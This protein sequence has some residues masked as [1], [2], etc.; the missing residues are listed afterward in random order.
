MT[1]GKANARTSKCT[2]PA[3]GVFFLLVL[4]ILCNQHTVPLVS[5]FRF[6]KAFYGGKVDCA[7]GSRHQGNIVE[8]DNNYAAMCSQ[9]QLCVL[10]QRI[11]ALHCVRRVFRDSARKLLG[12]NTH[13]ATRTRQ[14]QRATIVNQ[15]IKR[16]SG[17]ASRF[18]LTSGHFARPL[19]NVRALRKTLELLGG[20]LLLIPQK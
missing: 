8:N 11:G 10:C 12:G 14:V 4:R 18:W 17:T 1:R 19:V 2:K 6:A 20:G 16:S 9:E 15:E 7:W 3:L 5:G 13:N